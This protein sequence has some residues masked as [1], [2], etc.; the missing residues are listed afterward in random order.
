MAKSAGTPPDLTASL[1][2]PAAGDRVDV[3]AFAKV[4]ARTGERGRESKFRFIS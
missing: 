1:A 4:E 2:G 3:A